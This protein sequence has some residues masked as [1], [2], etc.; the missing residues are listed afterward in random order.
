MVRNRVRAI[1]RFFLLLGLV[2]M[3]VF[4][5]CYVLGRMIANLPPEDE[6]FM[7][8]ADSQMDENE[9]LIEASVLRLDGI[10]VRS[11]KVDSTY[12]YY[13]FFKTGLVNKGSTRHSPLLSHDFMNYRKEVFGFYKI[14]VDTIF[15]ELKSNYHYHYHVK[16][17]LEDAR[18]VSISP[19]SAESYEFHYSVYAKDFPMESKKK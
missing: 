5:G 12:N 19:D 13:K 3:N 9:N 16:Y 1:N 17:L 7:Y 4:S 8:Y 15:I 11:N 14:S 2:G 6:S 10:Y 18:L